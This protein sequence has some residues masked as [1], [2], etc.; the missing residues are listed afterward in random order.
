MRFAELLFSNLQELVRSRPQPP[1]FLGMFWSLSG[2][3]AVSRIVVTNK[4]PGLNPQIRDPG[5][6]KSLM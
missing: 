4:T 2:K 3:G 1:Q 5:E 6:E